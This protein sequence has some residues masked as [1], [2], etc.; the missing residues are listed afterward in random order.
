MLPNAAAY[1]RSEV[2]G[3]KVAGTKVTG[4]R[5]RRLIKGWV[6]EPNQLND[7]PQVAQPAAR[8]TQV[9]ILP[10]PVSELHKH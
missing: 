7:S 10:L 6:R 9:Y 1:I 4:P 5:P 2:A 3:P 8:G